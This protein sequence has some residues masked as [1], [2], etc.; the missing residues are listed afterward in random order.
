MPEHQGW[1]EEE[2][3]CEVRRSVVCVQPPDLA[4]EEE[5]PEVAAV[6][7][8]ADQAAAGSREEVAGTGLAV[9]GLE[10]GTDHVLAAAVAGCG[11]VA[12]H[13]RLLEC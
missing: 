6:G 5:F 13:R 7:T 4:S 9:A 10:A 3:V 11:G 12:G 8:L 1:V 2:S